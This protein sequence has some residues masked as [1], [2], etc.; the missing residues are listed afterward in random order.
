MENYEAELDFEVKHLDDIISIAEKQLEAVRESNRKHRSEFIEEKKDIWENKSYSAGNLW[1]SERFYELAALGQYENQASGKLSRMEGE[2]NKIKTLERIIQSPYF[3]R[4]DFLFEGEEEAEKIY[5]GRASLMNEKEGD[6]HVYDW[7]SPLASVFYR[8]GVGNAFY[9]A[10]GGKVSGEVS[11]KRQFEIHYGKLEYFFD[12]DVQIMDEFLRK[13]LSKNASSSMKAIVETIQKDQDIVIRDMENDLM[14]VQGVAGSGKTSIALHRAAYLMYQGL[15]TRLSAHNI[16][17][18]SPNTL[19]EQYISNVI[20]ELGEDNI[21]SVNFDEMFQTILPT[22]ELQPRHQ[23]LERIMTCQDQERRRLMNRNVAFKASSQFKEILTRFI[24]DIPRKWIGFS[25]VD[26]DGKCIADRELLKAEIL[27]SKRIAPLGKQLIQQED[28][29]LEKVHKMQTSRMKKLRDFVRQYREH[30]F[31]V[32]EFARMLSISESTALIGNIRR[33]TRLDLLALYKDLFRDPGYFRRLAKG[34]ELP[35]DVD[36]LLQFTWETLKE[37]HLSYEDGLALTFLQLKL[38]GV[39]DRKVIKQIVLDEAQDYYPLHFEILKLLFPNARYTVLADIH[40]TIEKSEDLT[41]FEQIDKIL[42]KKK[43]SLIT[44]N[45]SF[46]CTNEILQFSKKFLDQDSEI[47]SFS[48]RGEEPQIYGVQDREALADRIINEV[49]LCREADYQSIGLLC[50]TETEAMALYERL[51]ERIEVR[52]IQ[53]DT[54]T[55]IKGVFILPLYMAKGLEFDAV[56]LCDVDR[57]HYFAEEDKKLLYIG[58]T[59]ALHRLNLFYA[60]EMSPLLR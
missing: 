34:I 42:D 56:L 55:S 5:I 1:S 27:G 32:D 30:I 15:S 31:E 41:F 22:V 19:F 40:Q 33:F 59:R 17:I 50:K 21:I 45:K 18:I 25:D 10:P 8:F 43:S 52:F 7:R 47:E 46:R 51:K 26:Y 2:E 6:I 44:M 14:M 20:P 29:I 9:D 28:S 13:L 58:C 16:M 48:R 24:D 3:A 54:V 11:L 53:S 23:L 49:Q 35:D 38:Y 60:G 39:K 36:Q 57:E 37:G 12:A 4:I